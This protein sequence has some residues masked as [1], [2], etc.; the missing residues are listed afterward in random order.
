MTT[1]LDAPTALFA[2]TAAIYWFRSAA[3]PLPKHETYWDAAPPDDPFVMALQLVTKMNRIAALFS[4]LSALC[5]ASSV[6]LHT[7]Q[8]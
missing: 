4:G 6:T 3:R 8:R 5:A 7:V 2:L 1:V